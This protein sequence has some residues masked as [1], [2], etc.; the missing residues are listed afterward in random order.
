MSGP[1]TL[2][3]SLEAPHGGGLHPYQRTAV[4]R[5]LDAIARGVRRIMLQAATGAGKTLIASAIT[6]EC[7]AQD[8][9]VAG[10]VGN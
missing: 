10:V 8:G 7:R 5:V 2:D 9:A 4:V 3:A 6:A 1:S